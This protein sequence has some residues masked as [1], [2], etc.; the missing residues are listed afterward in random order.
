MTDSNAGDGA[1][2]G[3]D[4]SAIEIFQPGEGC[5]NFEDLGHDN[6]FR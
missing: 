3:I 6:G 5:Y 2:N 1:P 4:M